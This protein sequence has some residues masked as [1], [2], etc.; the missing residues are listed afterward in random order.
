MSN[1]L[2]PQFPSPRAY[3][4][5]IAQEKP[6]VVTLDDPATIPNRKSS[7]SLTMS[8]ST[9]PS[10]AKVPLS[11]SKTSFIGVQRA[12]IFMSLT[13]T[14]TLHTTLQHPSILARLI[15][16]MGWSDLYHLLCTCQHIRDLFRDTALRDVIL[17]RYVVG[18]GHCLRSRDLNHFQDVQISIYDLDL[19]C[20]FTNLT[21]RPHT[22]D[23][24]TCSDIPT[25]RSTPISHACPTHV[26]VNLP[27]I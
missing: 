25:F 18:Y 6:P 20:M 22:T 5:P 14:F 9:L 15:A 23:E 24:L 11:L 10:T 1:L 4:P 19:L 16:H 27:N 12:C 7:H 21:K 3:P 13:K 2:A 8:E 26:N 17:T